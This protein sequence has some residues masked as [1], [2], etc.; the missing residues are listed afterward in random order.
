VTWIELLLIGAIFVT[1]CAACIAL[2]A[3][4]LWAM[5]KPLGDGPERIVDIE[6]RGNTKIRMPDGTIK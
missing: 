3:W 2:F 1:L 5:T 6:N 4:I